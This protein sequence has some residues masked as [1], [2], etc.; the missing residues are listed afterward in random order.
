MGKEDKLLNSVGRQ[1]GMTVPERYFDEFAAN[2][3]ARLPEYPEKPVVPVL[4]RW[5]RIKPYV[6][7]AAMFA[8]IWCMMKMFHIASQNAQANLDAVPEPVVLAMQE[9]AGREYI[10]YM[11]IEESGD[12]D[13]EIETLV[14]ESYT[15]INDFEKDFGY[16]ISPEYQN[17]I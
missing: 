6:Y 16:E 1:H 10:E 14:S 8:G 17:M 15:S 4:S 11:D 5:Q 12:S 2:M 7:M 13:F 9:P 3:M